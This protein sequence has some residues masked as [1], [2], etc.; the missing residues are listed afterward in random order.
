[1]DNHSVFLSKKLPVKATVDVVVVGGGPAG[2]CAAG[3]A[4]RSGVK[5]LLVEKLGFLGGMATAGLV[6]PILGLYHWAS[7]TRIAGGLP[8]EFLQGMEAA[9]GA[10]IHNTG[11]L[12][13]FEAEI[14]KRVAD[15]LMYGAGV[16][17]LLHTTVVSAILDGTKLTH[18]IVSGPEG[19]FAIET[20]FC[21]DCSG[22]GFVAADIGVPFALGNGP[23]NVM[24]PMTTVFRI[25]GVDVSQMKDSENPETGYVVNSI[26][27]VLNH[28]LEDGAI[29]LFGGP[30]IMRGSTLRKNQAFVNMVRQWGN[31]TDA[32]EISKAERAGRS[33]MDRL[34]GFLKAN[35]VA[36]SQA[37][38]LDSGSSIGIRDSRHF[39]CMKKLTLEEA[40]GLAPQ[41]DSIG[42]G[43]HIVDIHSTDGSTAQRRDTLPFYE[44]PLRSMVPSEC[45]NLLICGRTI[46]ADYEMFASLRVMVTCMVLGQGA[47]VAA[48]LCVERRIGA[49]QIVPSVLQERLKKGA[50]L[51]HRED[52][53]PI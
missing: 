44:I 12:V 48:A 39:K 43:G 8:Y 21:I 46:D 6:G 53:V 45:S 22:D 40:L 35:V 31:P 30:W 41:E 4:A 23:E 25:G 37:Y 42:L 20:N 38:I 5:T 26:R 33:D 51:V 10:E 3:S 15:D 50:A 36:L 2:I 27:E 7:R 14:M 1:M 34:F 19:M 52:A 16:E 18:I 11:M 47:G 29:P 32:W 17:V 9:G 49:Q 24:M 28:G 13:P